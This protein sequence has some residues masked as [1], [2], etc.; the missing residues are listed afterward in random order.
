M[1]P[2]VPYA[3]GSYTLVSKV[4]YGK[5]LDRSRGILSNGI[6]AWSH[7]E[8]EQSKENCLDNKPKALIF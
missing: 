8:L 7:N 5:L 3:W 2:D 6:S 4:A 1:V